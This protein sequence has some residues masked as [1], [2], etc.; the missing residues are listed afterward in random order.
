MKTKGLNRMSVVFTVLLSL[1]AF[2][3]AAA[4]E[5]EPLA[6]VDVTG[7]LATFQPLISYSQVR[8]TVTGPEGFVVV[9]EFAAGET[10]G[11]EL[12]GD[13]G[14]YK[15]ELRFS[16]VLGDEA[17]LALAAARENGTEPAGLEKRSSKGTVQ[18]GSFTIAGG[19]LVA[20]VGEIEPK[21]VLTNGDGVIRNSL[22]VG[23]DCPDAPVFSD[24]TILL[25]ENNTR[26]KFGDTSVAPFPNN[27][28]EI[29]ANS[30]NSG[31][32]SYLGFNDCGTADND[33]GCATDLVFAVEA[34]ARQ[35]ALYV[36]SDGDIGIG[37]SNPV[38]DIH[39]VTGN[40]PTL[41]LDQDGSSG[42]APQVWDIAGNETTFF[43]RDVT[44]GSRLPFRIQPGAPS[45]AV[46]ITAGGDV[47][48]NTASPAADLHIDRG[49]SQ[50]ANFRVS[51][52]S[53][54]FDLED[55]NGAANRK[56]AQQFVDAGLWRL[57]GLNDTFTGE[58]VTGIALDLSNGRVGI[59][60]ASSLL[61]PL[62]VGTNGTNGNG[63][64]VTAGGVWIDGS[65]RQFKEAIRDLSASDAMAAFTGLQPV[66]FRYKLEP[67]E[68]YMGFIAEDVPDLVATNDHQY[69][70]PMD[71]VAVLT[72]VVQEQQKTI[73]TLGAKV[74][75][76]ESKI[77]P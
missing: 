15:Y 22:C 42:F 19:N 31:G 52:D 53:A 62:T 27:D 5:S 18:S 56:V 20:E 54:G 32:A 7:A 29:E 63:A 47:G 72:K 50:A 69:L 16:P 40:T 71:I 73:E 64:H 34:G 10:P 58:T 65:S 77:D 35:S 48:F 74:A 46:F 76:L 51:G 37:T 61:D 43:I 41:R 4:Q 36:E 25:M 6:Q 14:F 49:T 68:E 26:I 44:G 59:G 60:N 23:L 1:L 70:S 21:G 12:T 57:R 8:V 9:K 55:K 67:E 33:G 39:V 38:A 24:S 13:D 17:R 30:A 3:L 66:R 28:W 11:I 75:K 2:P 45:N